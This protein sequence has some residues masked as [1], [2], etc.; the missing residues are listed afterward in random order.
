MFIYFYYS[1]CLD[2]FRRILFIYLYYSFINFLL[3]HRPSLK[4][5]R[6]FSGPTVHTGK[7]IKKIILKL[8]LNPSVAFCLQ[9]LIVCFYIKSIYK[10]KQKVDTETNR[11]SCH[12][13]KSEE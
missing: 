13:L 6:K 5:Q 12:L 9:F 3:F 7:K 4:V 1:S 8:I 10:K 2:Y 11:K